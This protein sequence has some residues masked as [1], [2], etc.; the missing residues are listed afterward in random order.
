MEDIEIVV[1]MYFPLTLSFV[2]ILTQEET[3]S[4][5]ERRQFLDSSDVE[6]QA[7]GE[8]LSRSEVTVEMP[9]DVST[10]NNKRAFRRLFQDIFPTL[11]TT[12]VIFSCK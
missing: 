10:R 11:K 5:D 12:V 2:N 1:S 8:Q 6:T 4:H 3:Q 7:P 9:S